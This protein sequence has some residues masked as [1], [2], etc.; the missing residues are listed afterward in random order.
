MIR[1]ITFLVLFGHA[2]PVAGAV[3]KI[4]PPPGHI[5]IAVAQTRVEPTIAANRDQMLERIREAGERSARLVVFPENALAGTPA[6]GSNETVE[7]SGSIAALQK[8]AIKHEIYVVFGAFHWAMAIDPLGRELF[9]YERV[10]GSTGVVLPRGF[11]IDG[12]AAHAI[13]GS[14]RRLRPVEETPILEGARLSFELA[15]DPENVWVAGLNSY[16]AVARAMRNNVWV[17]VANTANPRHG[18][19]AFIAPD[20]EVVASLDRREGLLVATI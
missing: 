12:I 7:I 20:G 19:S 18:R 6:R 1:A 11:E 2:L 5:T 16:T 9:R 14:G 4:A 3:T 15:N 8:A 10:S 17:I 13:L